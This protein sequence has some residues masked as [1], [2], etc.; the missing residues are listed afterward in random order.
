MPFS[1]AVYVCSDMSL[2][3]SIWSQGEEQL[4]LASKMPKFEYGICPMK[5]NQYGRQNGRR[6]LLCICGHSK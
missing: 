1:Y 6:L 5:D 4:L 3:K 2:S